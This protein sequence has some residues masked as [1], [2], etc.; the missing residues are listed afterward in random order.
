MSARNGNDFFRLP[1]SVT[2]SII[3][4]SNGKRRFAE[5]TQVPRQRLDDL[6]LA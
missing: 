5:K 4:F 3:A 6:G 2:L 1:H